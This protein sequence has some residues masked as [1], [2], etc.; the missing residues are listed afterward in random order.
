MRISEYEPVRAFGVCGAL[1]ERAYFSARALFSR[2]WNHPASRVKQEFLLG[3][4][5]GC[6]E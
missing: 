1:R 3:V 5:S 2:Q 6:D 4:K